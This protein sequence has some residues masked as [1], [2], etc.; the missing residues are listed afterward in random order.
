ME[1]ILLLVGALVVVILVTHKD[2][3][4]PA[5]WNPC[6]PTGKNKKKEDSK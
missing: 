3:C 6:D 5:F 4:D 2:G 1:G